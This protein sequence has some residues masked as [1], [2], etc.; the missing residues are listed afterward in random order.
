M[1]EIGDKLRQAREKKNISINEIQEMTKIRLRYL[2]AIESG[3]LEIIPGE[4]YRK[5]FITNYANAVGLDS[6]ELI[7]EYN[8]YKAGELTP[9]PK[10]V[11]EPRLKATPPKPVAAAIKPE[12][13]EKGASASTTV[14][15]PI[16]EKPKKPVAINPVIIWVT[17]GAILT[18]TGLLFFLNGGPGK[19]ETIATK[20]ES[21]TQ[22]VKTEESANQP[23][24]S[25]YKKDQSETTVQQ[26]YPAPITVY[27]EFSEAVW[28]QVKT[29]GQ[30][31]Y[32]GSGITFD[33]K[34]PKQL[35][36]ANSEMVIRIGNPAG[37]KLILN[38]KDLG[39]LGEAGKA[40]TVTLT[41]NGMIES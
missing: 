26:I 35:W 16:R 19:T 10:T 23:V 11:P 8:H 31:K 39:P 40:K 9:E 4:V 5:G 25:S 17:A 37:M 33:A 28:V 20:Q 3:N 21:V 24:A 18:G 29:D 38:G 30:V 32:P 1:K 41:V 7:R 22:V 15:Q 14:T 13:K 27:A 34:S 2:E 6:D 12:I 36:T